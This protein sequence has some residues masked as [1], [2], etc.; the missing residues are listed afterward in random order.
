MNKSQMAEWQA[1][2]G[3]I[4]GQEWEPFVGVKDV[5]ALRR[6]LA[7]VPFFSKGRRR[8][9]D[10]KISVPAINVDFDREIST[11]TAFGNI[12]HDISKGDSQLARRIVTTSPDMTGTTSLGPWVNRRKLFAR[13]PQSDAFS[14]HRIPSTAKWEFTPQGQ[15]I[16]LGIAEMNLMLFL[17][18]AGLSHSLFANRLIP[19]GTVYDPFVCRGLDALNY[20]C[21]QDARFMLVGTPS[22]VTLAPEGGAHQSIGTPL[23]GMSQGMVSQ[24]L[25]RRLLMNWR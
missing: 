4:Q 9:S 13:Q 25:N 3:V 7:Q 8:Y 21:Y 1:H 22:G 18:A 12:L 5:P 6:F 19:I 23:V 15:H 16:E 14:E 2:M 10:D 17:G 20:A 24:A 11:Q